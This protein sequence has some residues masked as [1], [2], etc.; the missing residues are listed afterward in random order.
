MKFSAKVTQVRGESK[1][2]TQLLDAIDT[3]YAASYI[4]EKMA[5]L[6]DDFASEHQ[7]IWDALTEDEQQKV[8]EEYNNDLKDR[9]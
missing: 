2:L 7:D 1:Q 8:R 4:S 3:K 9:L 6:F 5:D